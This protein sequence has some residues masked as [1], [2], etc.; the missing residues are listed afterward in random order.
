[1]VQ[2]SRQLRGLRNRRYSPFREMILLYMQSTMLSEAVAAL[3][4]V[5]LGRQHISVTLAAI[6][7]TAYR[8]TNDDENAISA[9]GG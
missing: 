8:Q 9:T 3:L 5:E 6:L 1:M 4:Y 7:R 2:R